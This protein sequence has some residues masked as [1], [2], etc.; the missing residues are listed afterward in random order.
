MVKSCNGCHSSDDAHRGGF[1]RDCNGCHTS[2]AWKPASLGR[3]R[4][5]RR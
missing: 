2:K 1:G 4:G 5:I 3:S